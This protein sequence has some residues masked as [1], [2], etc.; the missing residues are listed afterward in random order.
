MQ[1]DEIYQ[2]LKQKYGFDEFR[3]GQYQVISDLLAGQDVL[4]VLPTGTGKSLIYQ[5]AGTL[6]PGLVVVISPLISLMQDQVAHL[7]YQGE[8]QVAA[9]TSQVDFQTRQLTLRQLPQLKF[10]FVSPEML[11]QPAVLTA[12]QRVKLALLVVDEAHCISTWGPDFRPDYLGLGQL[13][14]QLGS[15]LT[16]M[17]TATATAQVR[18][19]I[20]QQL[21]VPQAQQVIYSMNRPNIYLAVANLSNEADKRER[22]R[23]LLT[24]AA[25]PAIVYFSS[26]KQTEL[27][28]E[29]L[30]STTNLRVAAYHAGLSA[31]DRFKIQQQ[32]MTGQLDVICATSAFG[33]GL[34]KADVRLVIHYHL[35]TTLADYVQEIGRAGRDGQQSLAVLLYAPGDEQLV[36]NLNELT[37]ASANQIQADYQ[38]FQQQQPV[39]DEL[40]AVLQFYWEHHYSVSQVVDI[41]DARQRQ[42]QRE[43]QQLLAYIQTADCRRAILMSHFGEAT[44]P[45]R[46][47]CCQLAGGAI[48]L[49]EL[50]LT[51]GS[52]TT[53][54]TTTSWKS[55]LDQLF[56]QKI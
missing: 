51:A 20:V 47:A 46:E 22:L 34:N 29:W 32:Y 48:P 53:T 28:A 23:Q 17:L 40:A 2:L 41:F 18:Q 16:L 49:A 35:P 33:M 19:D 5:F 43:L 45:H 25:T 21:Q 11:K 31:E 56:L 54:P 3:P 7:N 13:K 50:G 4:A 10:L 52:V 42:K 12:I 39:P 26:K 8:K 9:L 1:R 44:V 38:R 36:R 24:T 55:L 27:I 37:M 6:L 15:P 14:Q 30:R